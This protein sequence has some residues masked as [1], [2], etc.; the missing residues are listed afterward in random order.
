MGE[1]TRKICLAGRRIFFEC[2]FAGNARTWA[3]II[4]VTKTRNEG[5]FSELRRVDFFSK[6][7]S[8]F[9]WCVVG[10]SPFHGMESS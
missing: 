8:S 6:S 4:G 3:R 7:A 2:G 5:L 1:E 9:Q 10:Q